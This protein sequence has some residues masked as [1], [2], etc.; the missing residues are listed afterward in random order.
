MKHS[1]VA[2]LALA[3]FTTACSS[4]GSTAAVVS[5][6]PEVRA[7]LF[8]A[9][10]ALEGTWAVSDAEGRSATFVYEVSSS[11]TVVRERM[12]AGTDHEMTNLYALDGSGLAMTHY[13]AGGNQPRMR[14]T[15]IEDGRMAFEFVRVDDLGESDEV[16]MGEVTLVFVDEDTCEQHWNAMSLDGDSTDHDMVFRLERR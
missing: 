13:C 4:T 15:S 9:V 14:A 11:G 7:T 12:H 8:D 6:D 1:L 2:S 3:L 5:G 16:F 10:A